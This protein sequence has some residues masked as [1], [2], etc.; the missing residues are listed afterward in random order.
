MI[1]K[2]KLSKNDSQ[3][4]LSDYASS[5]S[6]LVRVTEQIINPSHRWT[7]YTQYCVRPKI[8]SAENIHRVNSYFYLEGTS[9]EQPLKQRYSENREKQYKIYVPTKF[10]GQ[11]TFNIQ[12]QVYTFVENDVMVPI[13]NRMYVIYDNPTKCCFR[14]NQKNKTDAMN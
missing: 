1:R 4:N 2:S 11:V 3:S 6:S 7:I 5:I 9:S 14:Y 12:L 13:E 8:H 10:Y